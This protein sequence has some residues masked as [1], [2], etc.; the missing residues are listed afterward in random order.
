MNLNKKQ[1]RSLSF[2]QDGSAALG[3]TV[4][5]LPDDWVWAS[6][7][8]IDGSGG[9]DDDGWEYGKDLIKFNTSRGEGIHVAS[10]LRVEC[11]EPTAVSSGCSPHA[12]ARPVVHCWLGISVFGLSYDTTRAD[13]AMHRLQSQTYDSASGK[14]RIG[15]VQAKEVDPRHATTAGATPAGVTLGSCVPR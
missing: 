8:K 13:F 11:I 7:W 5:K 9:R 6:E 1:R 12:C 15:S 10:R 3:P 4:I 2:S 14:A